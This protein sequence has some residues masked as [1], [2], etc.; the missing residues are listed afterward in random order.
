[1]ERI[2]TSAVV[3]TVWRT[4]FDDAVET[5]ATVRAWIAVTDG[6]GAAAIRCGC[7]GP[8]WAGPGCAVLTACAMAVMPAAAPSSRLSVSHVW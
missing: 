7:A 1:V 6:A 5:A 8:G 4:E 2:T 3:T